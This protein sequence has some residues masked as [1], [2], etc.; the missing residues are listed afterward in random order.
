MSLTIQLLGKPRLERGGESVPAPRGHKAWGLLSYLI[1]SRVREPSREHLAEILFA[2]AD[3]PLGALRWNLAELR[4]RLGA[5][6]LA[7]GST[8]LT[9]PP[10]AFIDVHALLRGSPH[11]AVDLSGLGQELLEAMDFGATPGF[12]SWLLNERR[13][14]I[15]AAEAALH[16]AAL[17]LLA[18]TEPGRA[19]SLASRLVELNP[20]DESFQELL[21]R[22]YAESGDREAA[23][24]QLR[25]CVDLFRSELERDPVPPVF[26]AAKAEPPRPPSAIGAGGNQ[27]ARAQ[28]QTGRSAIDAGAIDAGLASLTRAVA[29]ASATGDRDLQSDALL[30]LGTALVH[31]GRGRDEEASTNLLRAATLAEELGLGDRAAAANRELAYVDVRQARYSRCA[32]RLDAA[33]ALVR[34]DA[35]RSG[36]EAIRGMAAADTGVHFRA[37]EHLRRSAKLAERSGTARQG[38]FS[39]SFL[40]R[41]HLICGELAEARVALEG[42]LAL[43]READWLT[44]TPWPEA[45]LAEVELAD[46]DGDAARHGLEHAFALGC[47]LGDPCW[48]GISGQGLGRLALRDGQTAHGLRLLE[49]AVRRLGQVPDAYAWVKA[50]SLAALASAAVEFDHR[51]ADAWVSD[52]ASLAAR[53]GMREFAV[54]ACLLRHTRGEA[55][56]YEAALVLAR[57]VENPLLHAELEAIQTRA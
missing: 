8:R 48:E 23:E 53:T 38:S 32:L 9:L 19:A 28:L 11:E 10:D 27:V 40:G 46:G 1:L 29:A 2:E 31:S 47:E 42:A 37:I 39:L 55:G 6:A 20:L 56:A 35:E 51:W 49:Q 12:D 13:R 43:A 18:A 14:L 4:R 24:R 15:G 5:A 34:S 57:E 30:A 21:I 7:R 52:L 16:D 50:Y 44:F 41:S 45:W 26:E 3:D 25:G 54:R 17:D 36:I 22:S 33:A